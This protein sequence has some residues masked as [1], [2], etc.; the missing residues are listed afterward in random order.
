MQYK[1][2]N[3]YVEF[4]CGCSFKIIGP[5]PFPKSDFPLIHFDG[6]LTHDD[7]T[8]NF[9][10]PRVWDIYAEGLTRGVFQLG[11]NLGR[12]WS[13][14]LKPES[15]D[16]LA[17]LV[18]LLRPGA[19]KAFDDKGVNMTTHYCLRKN[20]EEEVVFFHP[21]LKSILEETYGIAVFQEQNLEIVRKLATFS[22]S[23]A[24]SLRKAIGKK[25]AEEMA[26]VRVKF[27]DGCAKQG[28]VT[29]AEAIQIFDWIEQSQRYQFNKSHAEGYGQLSFID[30][31]Q[32]RH[33][34]MQFYT[35][36]LRRACNRGKTYEIIDMFYR[37]AKRA[38]IPILHPSLIKMNQQ[39]MMDGQC[40]Y[41]G[42]SAIR[43]VGPSA[44]ESIRHHLEYSGKK[45]EEMSWYTFLREILNNLSSDVARRLIESNA[46]SHFPLQRKLMLREFEVLHNEITKGQSK[47]ILDDPSDNLL[48]SLRNCAKT[49]KEGGGCHTQKDVEKLKYIIKTLEN[50]PFP[51]IDTPD[52][53]IIVEKEA[54]GVSI[55]Y[56]DL[57]KHDISLASHTCRDILD[58]H[59]RYAVL[60]VTLDRVHLRKIKKGKNIGKDMAIL[61]V[62]DHSSSLD[63]VVCFND[64]FEEYGTL[65]REGGSVF[66][67]GS[68][69]REGSFQIEKIYP[70][71]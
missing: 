20:K 14:R 33:F 66:I 16:H 51:L 10:C 68:V 43:G 24:D 67:S 57:D 47:F 23:E 45:L 44:L 41:F 12:Q 2:L 22:E 4:E 70:M 30:A 5:P 11:S 6:D 34:P 56:S 26:K 39:F 61:A 55:S 36:Q 58:G 54:L 7:H 71:E 28:I 49:K 48:D 60:G 46:L 15:L 19:L 50:P 63:G 52:W 64:V 69:N 9:S 13:E 38:D 1:I 62:S 31:Y 35:S 29:E 18:S 59:K 8:I 21:A 37:E 3:D 17:A 32:K 25:I 42:I 53:S 27:I 65:L 40:I